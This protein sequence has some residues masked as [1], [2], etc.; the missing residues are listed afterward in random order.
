[1]SDIMFKRYITIVKVDKIETNNFTSLLSDQLH[2][3]K[4]EETKC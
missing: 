2:P 3:P 1:M 4:V